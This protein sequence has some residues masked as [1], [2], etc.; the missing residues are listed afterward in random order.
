MPTSSEDNCLDM[1][2]A[3]VTGLN[4]MSATEQSVPLVDVGRIDFII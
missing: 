4:D 1:G 3:I 2:V